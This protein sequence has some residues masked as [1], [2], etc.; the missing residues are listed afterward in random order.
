[1]ALK[2]LLLLKWTAEPQ[3]IGEQ[4]SWMSIELRICRLIPPFCTA[5]CGR[6]DFMQLTFCRFLFHCGSD[7]SSTSTMSL[8]FSGLLQRKFLEKQRGVLQHYFKQFFKRLHKILPVFFKIAQQNNPIFEKW[9]T[10]NPVFL[11]EAKKCSVSR[12]LWSIFCDDSRISRTQSKLI[13]HQFY[14]PD[15]CWNSKLFF[16]RRRCVIAVSKF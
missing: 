14:T 11:K 13:L 15:A 3:K 7:V 10:K 1:M 12:E 16:P 8:T 5:L 2:Y 9:V 6:G 4:H